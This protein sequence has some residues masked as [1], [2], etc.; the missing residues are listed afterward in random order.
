MNNKLSTKN[1][2]SNIV[3]MKSFVKQL[4]NRGKDYDSLIKYIT[5]PDFCDE[6]T[7]LPAIK[8]VQKEMGL[9]YSVLRRKLF[10][11]YEDLYNHDEIGIDFSIKK[12]EYWFHM[13]YFDNQAYLVLS[14]LPRVPRIGEHM[15]IPFFSAKVGTDSF[16]VHDISHYLTDTKQIIHITLN[17]GMYNHF[18]RLRKDEAFL[19][20]DIS[21][22]DYFDHMDH[23]IKEK[24]RLPRYLPL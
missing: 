4:L 22:D 21:W 13:R 20:G 23:D 10:S 12:T 14:D 2:L 8:E 24:L 15:S 6:D 7:P 3:S 19:K 18:W 16:Y 17:P 11:I 5:S 9:S 1:V